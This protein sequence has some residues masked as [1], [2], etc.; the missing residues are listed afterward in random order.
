MNCTD[1]ITLR[2]RFP[3]FS[4]TDKIET[5][6]MIQ[7]LANWSVVG[8]YQGQVNLQYPQSRYISP[9]VRAFVNFAK[10]S[11]GAGAVQVS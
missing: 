4:V 1:C 10:E 11:L 5:G 6:V 8:K 2:V 9:L 7:I 3:D